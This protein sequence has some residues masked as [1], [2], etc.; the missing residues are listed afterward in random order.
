MK[1]VDGHYAYCHE[2]CNEFHKSCNYFETIRRSLL[3]E[4][5][6]NKQRKNKFCCHFIEN[7]IYKRLVGNNNILKYRLHRRLIWTLCVMIQGIIVAE[8]K[9]WKFLTKTIEPTVTLK[10]QNLGIRKYKALFPYFS[11]VKLDNSSKIANRPSSN[12]TNPFWS[13]ETI[14]VSKYSSYPTSYLKLMTINVSKYCHNHN[15]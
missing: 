11:W 1:S 6:R 7:L 5:Q 4:K 15:I 3:Y 8:S 14:I 10:H 9:M 13:M 12:D 2:Y